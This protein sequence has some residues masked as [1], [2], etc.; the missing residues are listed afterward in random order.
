MMIQIEEA[1]RQFIE[2][3]IYLPMYKQN[4]YLYSILRKMILAKV[5]RGRQQHE[6]EA[7]GNC[8]LEL[9]LHGQMDIVC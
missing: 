8:K 4:R 9:C 7:K 6:L 5:L 1:N 3:T 2:N